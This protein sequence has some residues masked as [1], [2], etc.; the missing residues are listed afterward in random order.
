MKTTRIAL[1]AASLLDFTIRHQ[2][3]AP[4]QWQILVCSPLFKGLRLCAHR[5][6][7]YSLPEKFAFDRSGNDVVRPG[8]EH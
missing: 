6:D 7:L 1:K 3:T 8:V 4:P 2:W 5:G